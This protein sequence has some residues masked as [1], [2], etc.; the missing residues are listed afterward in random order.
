MLNRSI[1]SE[2]V[3]EENTKV[4]TFQ[5]I[6]VIAGILLVFFIPLEYLISDSL[7]HIEKKSLIHMQEDRIHSAV[8]FFKTLTY[9]GNHVFLIVVFPTLYHFY[10]SRKAIKIT[11]VV[12]IAMYLNSFL[13]LIYIEPRP[14]WVTSDITGEICESGFGN[15]VQEIMLVTILSVYTSYVLVKHRSLLEQIIAYTV[16][17]SIITLYFTSAMYLGENFPHQCIVTICFAFIYLTS[18]FALDKYI[19]NLSFKCCFDYTKNRK[20]SVYCFIATMALLLAII[21]VNSLITNKQGI[22]IL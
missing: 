14:F 9:I 17:V 11:M 20:N 19:T 10:D 2:P 6:K 15:P 1:Q 18:A 3:V 5:V 22:D 21:S 12:C 13:A 4:L 16:C 8:V 7:N